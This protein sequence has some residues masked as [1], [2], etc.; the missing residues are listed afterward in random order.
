MAGAGAV[1]A[2][3]KQTFPVWAAAPRPIRVLLMICGC[4]SLVILTWIIVTFRLQPLLLLWSA[5]PGYLK[6]ILIL[7]AIVTIPIVTWWFVRLSRQQTRI[8]RIRAQRILDDFVQFLN[9]QISQHERKI[10]EITANFRVYF[11]ATVGPQGPEYKAQAE[12]AYERQQQVQNRWL[13]AQR[14][15][16]DLAMEAGLGRVSDTVITKQLDDI[17]RQVAHTLELVR[18]TTRNRCFRTTHAGAFDEVW[19]TVCRESSANA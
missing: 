18:E 4:T 3:L 6:L 16:E 17:Q 1:L 12:A 7:W 15:I 5:A 14:G 10:E 8:I 19:K 13:A 11:P 2:L 9:Q